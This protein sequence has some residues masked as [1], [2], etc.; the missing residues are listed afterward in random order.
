MSAVG[1]APPSWE[2]PLDLTAHLAIT[3]ASATIKG[4]FTA[5]LRPEALR[6]G[7][8]L[9]HLRP[10]YIPF[11]D[12]PMSDHMQV[13]CE[14]ARA[15][16]PGMPLRQGLRIL[17]RTAIRTF[18]GSTVGR[19]MLG[20]ETEPEPVLRAIVKA[21]PIGMTHAQVDLLE[22][23]ASS[24]RVRMRDVWHFLD[25][26]QVGVFEGALYECGMKAV[27][28]VRMESLATGELHL[29]WAP[30]GEGGSMP[31]RGSTMPP[32]GGSTP[33]SSVR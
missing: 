4:L 33:P 30:R 5:P 29:A 28:T 2:S 20:T 9:R 16:Y 32:R 13:F 31:P 7:I 19:V 8:T 3:P 22:V 14:A 1:F 6:R 11:K 12:Y 18:S 23:T 26:H 17:G 21:Y 15:F 27:V 24:A 10:H 25:S